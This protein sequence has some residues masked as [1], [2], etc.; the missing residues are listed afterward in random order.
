MNDQLTAPDTYDAVV[1]GGGA[2]GLSAGLMLA[3]ARRAVAVIDAGQP[4]NAPAAAVHGLFARDGLSPAQLLALG[5]TEVRS[6]GGRLIDAHVTAVTGTS[7]AFSVALA[8]GRALTARRVLVATGV[9]DTLPD[10]PGLREQWGDGVIHCPYC[11][12]WEVRDKPIGILAVGPMAVH[13]ALL[14][15]QWSADVALFTH[16]AAPPTPEQAEQLAARD[17]PVIDGEVTAVESRDGRLTG[18]R[19]ADGTLHARDAV[20]VGAPMEVRA[21]FLAPL[22]LTP[23]TH[24]S[25]MATHL[26]ADAMGRTDVPGLYVAGNATDPTAQVGAAASAAALA[27]ALLNADLVTEETAQAVAARRAL[28]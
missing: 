8:D 20:A 7:G 10:L 17:I 16:T 23:Q 3:R 28:V 1:I 4:R 19:L 14:F 12:G 5:R 6:Y 9:T 2:A 15:R 21:D 13:Q 11:H 25:G 26:P 27:A 18:L 22:G 24:P